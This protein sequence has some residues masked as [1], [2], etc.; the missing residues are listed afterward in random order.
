MVLCGRRRGSLDRGEP[1]GVE[2]GGLAGEI[3]WREADWFRWDSSVGI[4]DQLIGLL[5]RTTQ[6]SL[7]AIQVLPQFSAVLDKGYFYPK[8]LCY[9]PT[10]KRSQQD[11]T[12]LGSDH[13]NSLYSPLGFYLSSSVSPSNPHPLHP[14]LIIPLPPFPQKTTTTVPTVLG[15]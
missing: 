14:S 5:P 6:S 13:W 11:G 10:D 9:S 12:S 8:L 15:I 2:G 4:L 7:L 3:V 1:A